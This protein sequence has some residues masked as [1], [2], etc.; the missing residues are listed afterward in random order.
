MQQILVI[1]IEHVGSPSGKRKLGIVDI[2]G[3]RCAHSS[4]R[5]VLQLVQRGRTGRRREKIEFSVC[6]LGEIIVVLP[7]GQCYIADCLPK[8]FLRY[9]RKLGGKRQRTVLLNL[10]VTQCNAA[11]CAVGID[12]RTICHTLLQIRCPDIIGRIFSAV[13]GTC[14][15]ALTGIQCGFIRTEHINFVGVAFIVPVCCGID[16]IYHHAV[17]V[18]LLIQF[19][20]I[21]CATPA[22][23]HGKKFGVGKR[24]F[25]QVQPAAL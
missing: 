6:S 20:G 1:L 8:L 23:F 18:D 19:I 10:N 22:I 13:A 15:V 25:Q 16:T 5:I 7:G 24:R 21:E 4:Q 14:Q 17:S 2:L 12:Q 11:V 9:V 3:K